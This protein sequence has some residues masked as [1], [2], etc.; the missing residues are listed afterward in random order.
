[1]DGEDDGDEDGEDDGEV[2]GDGD[3]EPDPPGVSAWKAV[4]FAV[5][6][7]VRKRMPAKPEVRLL[8]VAVTIQPDGSDPD[9]GHT[10]AVSVEPTTRK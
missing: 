10:F 6:V 3:G 7:W 4:I 2:D 8:S 5:P 1:V 9:D